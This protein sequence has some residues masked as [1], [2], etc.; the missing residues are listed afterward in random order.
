ME[1]AQISLQLYSLRRQVSQNLAET[2]AS[3]ARLGYELVEP[4]GFV[5]RATELSAA[6]TANGLSA[7]SAHAPLV[8]AADVRPTFA[9][10]ASLA[11]GVVI[12]P[13]VPAEFWRSREDVEKTASCL[14]ELVGTAAEFGLRI[15]YH[16]HDWEFHQRLRGQSA[17]EYF[18][19]L[20]HPDV[21]LEVDTYWATVGGAPT[22]ELLRQL[23]SR[24]EFLHLKDGPLNWDL[25][26]QVALGTG[27][28]PLAEILAAA[29]HALRIVEFDDFAG[30]VMIPIGESLA[31][32][33][34]LG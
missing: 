30:D 19:D 26:A 2:L 24:V 20:L 14:N 23:G 3:V 7:P 10:A 27:S 28:L 34:A 32:L 5:D 16:N 9:A 11:V 22:A 4:Y 29:P 1:T 6:L 31:H 18:T 17:Y 25:P 13:T 33:E 12:E 15:G 8:T 21:V